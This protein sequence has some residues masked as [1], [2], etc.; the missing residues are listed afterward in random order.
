LCMWEPQQQQQPR[1]ETTRP[2]PAVVFSTH[3]RP[4][5][6]LPPITLCVCV[7]RA[8]DSAIK[9]KKEFFFFKKIF[10][11]REQIRKPNGEPTVCPFGLEIVCN[12]H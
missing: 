4:K 12:F 11:L 6:L 2:T 9:R 5:S 1:K 7:R 8:E 10:S 3:S